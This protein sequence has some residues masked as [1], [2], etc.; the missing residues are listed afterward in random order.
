[1]V[2]ISTVGLAFLERWA[3]ADTVFFGHVGD[4]N[5]HIGVKVCEGE[6]PEADIEA[7]VYNAVRDW[8]GSVSAEHGI[9]TL[10]RDYLAHSR[11][12]AE[13]ALMRTFQCDEVQGYLCARPMPAA[14]FSEWL[15]A[16]Q[17]EQADTRRCG[18]VAV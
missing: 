8:R 14:A 15:R 18:S 17:A 2:C 10:K 7:L 6:Q 5:V 3:S 13:L 16:R 1:M 9:G 4:A 12:P 11:S